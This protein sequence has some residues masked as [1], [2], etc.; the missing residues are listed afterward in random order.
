MTSSLPFNH[1]ICGDALHVLKRLPN[2][3]IDLSVTDQ[4]YGDNIGYGIHNRTIPGNEHPLIALSVMHDA[5]RLLKANASAYMFCGV[6]HLGFLRTFFQSY[7]KYGI[8]TH[9]GQDDVG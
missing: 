7:T 5:Y 6:R 8:H 1:I 2:K 9:L 3:S 4:P